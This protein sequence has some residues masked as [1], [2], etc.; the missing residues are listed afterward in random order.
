MFSCEFIFTILKCNVLQAKHKPRN[1]NEKD[2]LK[3]VEANISV[4]GKNV[5][6]KR[7]TVKFNTD[8]D[9]LP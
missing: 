9:L 6:V 3:A 7:Q 4:W 5:K 2:T 8:Q 1:H